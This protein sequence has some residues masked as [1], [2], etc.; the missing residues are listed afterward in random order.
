MPAMGNERSKN[1]VNEIFNVD[2]P[3]L[4][5][6]KKMVLIMKSLETEY[7]AVDEFIEGKINHLALKY[8]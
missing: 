6:L 3:L 8:E 4:N 7:N 2:L 1:Y 5:G